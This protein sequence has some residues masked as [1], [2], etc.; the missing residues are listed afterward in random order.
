MLRLKSPTKTTLKGVPFESFLRFPLQ[1]D[2]MYK[3]RSKRYQ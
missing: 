1:W 3:E 2:L